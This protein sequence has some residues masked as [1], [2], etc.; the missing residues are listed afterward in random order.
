ML[1]FCGVIY[2]RA[3]VRHKHMLTPPAFSSPQYM[4]ICRAGL[5]LVFTFNNRFS[6]HHACYSLMSY[7]LQSAT[8][9]SQAR[10]KRGTRQGS[11]IGCPSKLVLKR[12]QP[13]LEPKLVSALSETKRLFRLFR[14][15]NKT[16]SCD[17][18][19]ETKQTEDQPKQFDREHILLFVY[20]KLRLFP[21]FV[22]FS[23]CFETVC[24]GFFASMPKQRVCREGFIFLPCNN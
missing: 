20:R 17:V 4:K 22:F 6:R 21:I 23:V 15:Y 1:A 18:S 19:M 11:R 13:K 3:P 8:I 12:N 10:M 2:K 16:E 24:F 14:F 5:Q 9:N 7:V